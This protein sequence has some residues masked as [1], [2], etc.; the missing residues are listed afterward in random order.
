MATWQAFLLGIMVAYTPSLL[1]LAIMLRHVR[2]EDQSIN[3]QVAGIQGVGSRTGDLPKCSRGRRQHRGQ[4]RSI[5]SR[6]LP[7]RVRLDRGEDR[8]RLTRQ[9]YGRNS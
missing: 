4:I 6:G 5:T 3:R 1:F 8:I 2:D 7:A 9:R